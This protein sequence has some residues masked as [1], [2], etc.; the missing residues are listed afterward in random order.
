MSSEDF[1]GGQNLSRQPRILRAHKDIHTLASE[2]AWRGCDAESLCLPTWNQVRYK[3][4][5]E[6]FKDESGARDRQV[7]ARDTVFSVL[8]QAQTSAFSGTE[9]PPE[10][11]R[12]S[13]PQR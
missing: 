11:V 8:G 13:Q 7:S 6:T 1:T 5:E 9:F 12:A 3:V 2:G 10:D 4:H